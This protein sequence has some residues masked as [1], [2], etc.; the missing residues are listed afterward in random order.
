MDM[1]TA[2]EVIRRIQ[3]YFTGGAAQFLTSRQRLAAQQAIRE[4][5]ASQ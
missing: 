3:L 4:T 5:Q 1:I 2:E